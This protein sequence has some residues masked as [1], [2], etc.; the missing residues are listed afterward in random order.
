MTYVDP[1]INFL[2]LIWEDYYDLQG[3]SPYDFS[4]MEVLQ[5]KEQLKNYIEDLKYNDDFFKGVGEL[6]KKWLKLKS[7]LIIHWYI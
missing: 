4:S 2:F 1:S 7:L 3:I 6:T 5:L